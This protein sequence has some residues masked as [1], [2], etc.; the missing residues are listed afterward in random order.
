MRGQARRR[1]GRRDE[2]RADLERAAA[3]GDDLGDPRVLARAWCWLGLLDIETRRMDDA[4]S[5]LARA[6]AL[7]RSSDDRAGEGHALFALG[8]LATEEGS[9]ER[10]AVLFERAVRLFEEVGAAGM[11]GYARMHLAG[12][13]VHRGLWDDAARELDAA[14]A[15]HLEVQNTWFA[16]LAICNAG[17]V[18]LA[19]GRPSRALEVLDRGLAMLRP[20]EDDRSYGAYLAH[21]ALALAALGRVDEARS[22][23][24]H[25]VDLLPRA[26]DVRTRGVVLAWS[27]G[28]AA[29]HGDLEA[30]E[31]GLADA[32]ALASGA[33]AK[34]A[35]DVI[36][37][38]RL[39]VDVARARAIARAGDEPAA[40][41][42][43]ARV[44]ERVASA[45]RDLASFYYAR[46]SLERAR[47]LLA[48]AAAPPSPAL[49]R[50][51]VDA[52][53]RWIEVGGDRRSIARKATLQ[54][55]LR[56]LVDARMTA[57][58]EPVSAEELVACGWPDE[59]MEHDAAKNRLRVAIARLRELGLDRAIVGLRGGYLV[60]PDVALEVASREGNDS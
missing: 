28:I 33:S 45:E 5:V 26:S 35:C 17:A 10:G 41:A 6:E 37:A 8:L 27:A 56:R 1:L 59:R 55:L 32:A 31:R 60:D 24:G 54:R 22:D 13:L 25:A 57:P 12:T 9:P 29:E 14:A 18:E 2:A 47:R 46:L 11:R 42:L 16:A 30:A 51:V 21:R 43:V 39:V 7:A 58:G 49:P 50:I 23:A 34:A 3:L 44:R 19:R 40:A 52:R 20:T 15:D 38:E 53:A 36:E 4:R 48:A